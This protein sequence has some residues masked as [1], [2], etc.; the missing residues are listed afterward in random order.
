MVEQIS[1]KFIFEQVI[2]VGKI[3]LQDRIAFLAVLR[4]PQMVE[5]LVEVPGFSIQEVA[6]A[7]GTCKAGFDGLNSPRAVP[8]SG[9]RTADFAGDGHPRA[10]L[11]SGMW[12][13]FSLV[14]F[15]AVLVLLVTVFLELVLELLTA[16]ACTW[17]VL[18]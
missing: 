12:V 16:V 10:F 17:L 1:D 18:L 11:A 9:T 7:L 14:W 15:T 4:A 3:H 2:V 13:M 8:D 6:R 5:Q